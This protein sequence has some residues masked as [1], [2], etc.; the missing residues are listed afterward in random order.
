MNSQDRENF[1][2]TLRTLP[3]DDPEQDIQKLVSTIDSKN[4]LNAVPVN[5]S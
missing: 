2:N 1:W 4:N 3:S 5:L